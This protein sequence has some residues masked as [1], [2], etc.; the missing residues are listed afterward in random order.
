MN[1]SLST[2]MNHMSWSVMLPMLKSKDASLQTR[3]GNLLFCGLEPRKYCFWY[4]YTAGELGILKGQIPFARIFGL[5]KKQFPLMKKRRYPPL[6]W[7]QTICVFK[8]GTSLFT[9]RARCTSQ[10]QP[11]HECPL[12]AVALCKFVHG[13]FLVLRMRE[14]NSPCW[15]LLL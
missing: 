4:V 8:H 1:P 7:S 5:Y 14:G 12:L 2:K 9:D 6:S 13:W 15:P 11:D 10:H 3:P